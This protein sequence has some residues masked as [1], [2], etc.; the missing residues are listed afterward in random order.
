MTRIR[1]LAGFMLPLAGAMALSGCITSP[2][3]QEAIR[4]AELE[5]RARL[6]RMIEAGECSERRQTGMRT[7]IVYE[8]GEEGTADNS[9]ARESVRRMQRQGGLCGGGNAACGGPM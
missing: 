2:E 5:E 7:R 1:R 4:Q 6:Q 8:C 9:T 3:E